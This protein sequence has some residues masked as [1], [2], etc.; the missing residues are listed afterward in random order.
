MTAVPVAHLMR[1]HP[2]GT[3]PAARRTP[4]GSPGEGRRGQGAFGKGVSD[5]MGTTV[6]ASLSVTRDVQRGTARHGTGS[7]ATAA[8]TGAPVAWA[9]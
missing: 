8:A 5:S 1:G 6:F 7:W 9:A 4:D 3:G 2:D